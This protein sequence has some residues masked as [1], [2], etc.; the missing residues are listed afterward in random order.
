MKKHIITGI[1]IIACVA[2]C[3]AVWPRNAEVEDLPAEL[4]KP[5]V[6]TEIK[7]RLEK[8]PEILH[9]ANTHTLE[10]ETVAEYEPER[11]DITTEKETP[12]PTLAQENSP[13][14]VADFRRAAHGRCSYHKRREANIY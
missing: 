2:L 10:P 12:I 6:V 11:A 9:S 5:A 14:S 1:A 8:T 7:A 13:K 4:I 3:A